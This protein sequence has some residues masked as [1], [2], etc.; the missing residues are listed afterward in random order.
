MFYRHFGN[1]HLVSKFSLTKYAIN[2]ADGNSTFYK[3][4]YFDTKI[5][6]YC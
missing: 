4:S 2:S 3:F 1:S 6:E 5:Y